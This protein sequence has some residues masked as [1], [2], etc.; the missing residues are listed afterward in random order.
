MSH[1]VANPISNNTIE[2]RQ[3]P[4]GDDT[5]IMSQIRTKRLRVGSRFVGASYGA[6]ALAGME[7]K[8]PAKASAPFPI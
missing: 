5:V 3:S 2:I 4:R 8:M 7:L 1:D 6:P